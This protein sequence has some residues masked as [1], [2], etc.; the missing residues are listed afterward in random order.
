MQYIE[1]NDIQKTI[2]DLIDYEQETIN[3]IL[4]REENDTEQ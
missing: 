4:R 3:K 2:S 1:A